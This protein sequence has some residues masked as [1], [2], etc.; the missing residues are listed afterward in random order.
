MIAFQFR[1]L[2]LVK[3]SEQEGSFAGNPFA[4]AGKLGMHPFVLRKTIQ[5]AKLFTFEELKKIYRDIFQA[6]LN[7]KTG[8][9]EP[10]TAIDLLIAGV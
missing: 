8:K 5:Q 1:N 4:L 3:S 2:L 9:I 6:D 7:I 10:A